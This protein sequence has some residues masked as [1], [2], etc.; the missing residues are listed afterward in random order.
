VLEHFIHQLQLNLFPTPNFLIFVPEDFRDAFCV[1]GSAL[2]ASECQ[3]PI[4]K[5][6]AFWHSTRTRTSMNAGVKSGGLV[7]PAHLK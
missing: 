3:L 6:P 7:V 1:A 2:G 5:V 4:C